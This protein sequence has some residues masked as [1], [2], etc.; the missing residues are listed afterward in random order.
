MFTTQ[1]GP[2]GLPADYVGYLRDDCLQRNINTYHELQEPFLK[3]SN[4]RSVGD[5]FMDDFDGAF[6]LA[7]PK[8]LSE[9]AFEQDWF[10]DDRTGIQVFQFDRPFAG[11]TYRMLHMVM[12]VKRQAPPKDQR[13]PGQTSPAAEDAHKKTIQKLF[14]ASVV[15]VED[16]VK[17]KLEKEL[18]EDLQD[19]FNHRARYYKPG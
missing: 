16:L 11:G 6:K 4:G 9:L 17:G 15:P 1:V 2:V 10:I 12:A 8:S 3:K 7:V 13:A 19:L 14:D 18:Q 5:F